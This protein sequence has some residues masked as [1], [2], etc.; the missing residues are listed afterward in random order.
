MLIAICLNCLLALFV[1]WLA[2]SLWRWRCHLSRLAQ[3]LE[4]CEG[5]LKL[6]PQQARYG[7]THRRVQIAQT[8]FRWVKFLA[9]W[10]QRSRQLKQL[11]QLIRLLQLVLLSRRVR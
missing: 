11:R 5:D 1:C 4:G 9:L 3:Q 6:L 2:L 8:Q 10:Q 7:L